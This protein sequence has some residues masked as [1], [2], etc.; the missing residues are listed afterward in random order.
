MN[1]NVYDFFIAGI[2]QGSR[3]DDEIFSQDY[4]QSIKKSLSAK[5]PESH[6]YCPVE[7]HPESVKYSNNRAR[8]VFMKHINMVHNADCL[9]V[10]LPEAS[11][12]T[13]IEIWEAYHHDT[14]IISVTSLQ[15]NWV[16]R[17][18]SDEIFTSI[19][20]FDA[21]VQS[22]QLHVRLKRGLKHKK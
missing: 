22:G 5:F 19:E 12:G 21:Y 6:I 14:L 10:Y 8:S 7:H 13:A 17:L 15:Y 20:Q 3:K 4:R 9:I 18:F 11:L 1:A 16:V 2:I